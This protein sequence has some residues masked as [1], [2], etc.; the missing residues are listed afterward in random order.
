MG[1]KNVNGVET[2]LAL[3]LL[4]ELVQGGNLPPKGRSGIAAKD[5]DDRLSAQ[6]DASSMGEW[7]SKFLDRESGQ[8]RR[9]LDCLCARCVHI[10]SKGRGSRQASASCHDMAEDLRRLAH[11]PI[12][13]ADEAEPKTE[14]H[15]DRADPTSALCSSCVAISEA[16]LRH[17]IHF[18]ITLRSNA[19]GIRD[20]VEEGKQSGNVDRLCDLWLV[21]P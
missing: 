7:S 21:Q 17:A 19:E 9:R 4:G 12:D 8:H 6:S 3:V 5:Q 18:K 10:V 20:P 1:L 14:Q 11:G 13:I 15:R 2:D 16:Q